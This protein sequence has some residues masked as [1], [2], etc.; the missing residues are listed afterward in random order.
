MKLDVLKTMA[1]FATVTSERRL[2]AYWHVF[3]DELPLE[4]QKQNLSIYDTFFVDQSKLVIS[5][6]CVCILR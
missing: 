2:T 6:F 4:T 1:V 5:Q 3:M